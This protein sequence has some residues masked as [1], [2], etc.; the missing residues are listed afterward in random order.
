MVSTATRYLPLFAAFFV[1]ILVFNWS[2]LV[3]PIGHLDGLRAP[4][5]DLNVTVGLALVAFFTFHIEGV[6]RLGGADVPLQVLP[7]R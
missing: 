5:S 2:G 6:R 4:T 3:P 1:L 7:L